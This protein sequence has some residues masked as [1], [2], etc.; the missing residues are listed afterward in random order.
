[1][2]AAKSGREEGLLRAEREPLHLGKDGYPAKHACTAASSSLGHTAT[3]AVFHHP[4]AKL[5]L[6]PFPIPKQATVTSNPDCPTRSFQN[7]ALAVT[8]S[9]V[10]LPAPL[11]KTPLGW[12]FHPSTAEELIPAPPGFLGH[13]WDK[14]TERLLT[15]LWQSRASSSLT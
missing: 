3:N 13:H 2:K 5:E 6:P 12:S 14:S 11:Q 9:T 8:C 15:Q 1:V 4:R 10:M 7:F